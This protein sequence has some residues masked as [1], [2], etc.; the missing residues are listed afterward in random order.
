MKTNPGDRLL[1]WSLVPG[2]ILALTLSGCGKGGKQG[3]EA[4]PTPPAEGAPAVPENYREGPALPQ[5][6]PVDLLPLPEGSAPV[7]LLDKVTVP[8]QPGEATSALYASSIS[9]TE[10]NTFWKRELPKKGWKIVDNQSG[11]DFLLITAEG[12]GYVG[13][14]GAGEGLGPPA[15]TTGQ[16]ISLQIVLT[17]GSAPPA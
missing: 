6:W 7:A 3:L 14:F 2:L 4:A 13:V 12:N 10:A 16:K 9:P 11:K 5:G 1:R 8:G 17:K 15:T